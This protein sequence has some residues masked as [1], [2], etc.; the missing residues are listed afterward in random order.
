MMILCKLK[1][2]KIKNIN[3]WHR[4]IGEYLDKIC[5]YLLKEEE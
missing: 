1:H 3:K 4:E 5:K 2:G